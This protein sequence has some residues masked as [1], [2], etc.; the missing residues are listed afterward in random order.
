MQL[1]FTKVML[2]SVDTEIN[3]VYESDIDV[4]LIK[5]LLN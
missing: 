3:L 2:I 4:G 1:I 5:Y